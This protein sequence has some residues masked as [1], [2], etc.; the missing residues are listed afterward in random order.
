[1]VH[2]PF[3]STGYS[4]KEHREAERKNECAENKSDIK[5]CST[6]F[7]NNISI[8]RMIAVVSNVR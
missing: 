2:L 3:H 4:V 1:M 8:N 6:G 7:G 5:F